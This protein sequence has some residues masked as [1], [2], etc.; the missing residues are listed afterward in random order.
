PPGPLLG[1]GQATSILKLQ[2]RQLVI[3]RAP[4]A[5]FDLG[6]KVAKFVLAK[7]TVDRAGTEKRVLDLCLRQKPVRSISD[8]P[9]RHD[10]RRVMAALSQTRTMGGDLLQLREGSLTVAPKFVG[11]RWTRRAQS[12]RGPAWP[13]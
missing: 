6:K 7:R 4:Q 3:G 11:T 12:R 1:F 9:A 10:E 5:I 13:Q 8:D 2:R